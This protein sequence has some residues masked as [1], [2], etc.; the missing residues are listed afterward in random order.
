[1]MGPAPHV[2]E[3]RHIQEKHPLSAYGLLASGPANRGGTTWG[4]NQN[5]KFWLICHR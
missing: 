3:G 1:M 2:P 5:K 4:L